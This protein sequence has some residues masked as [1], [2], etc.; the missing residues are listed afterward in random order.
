MKATQITAAIAP[1]VAALGYEC[2]G[3]EYIPQGRYSILRVFIDSPQGVNLEDCEKVSKQVSA[4]LDVE[5]VI[6]GHFN[7][8]VSSPG[9]D[10]PLFSLQQYQ[11]FIGKEVQLRLTEKIAGHRKLKGQLQSVTDVAVVIEVDEAPITIPFQIIE[12]GNLTGDEKRG[13]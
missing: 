9:I 6:A 10:R 5:D 7:L 13:V 2:W 1:A 12:K 11:R 4:V 3:C 8:E